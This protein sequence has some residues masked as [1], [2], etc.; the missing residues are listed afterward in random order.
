MFNASMYLAIS[1]QTHISLLSIQYRP[2]FLY[3]PRVFV[4]FA[5]ILQ[6]HDVLV[7][8]AVRHLAATITAIAN[9]VIT[10]TVAGIAWRSKRGG[11]VGQ[12]RGDVSRVDGVF[13]AMAMREAADTKIRRRRYSENVRI[14]NQA[15][16]DADRRYGSLQMWMHAMSMHELLRGGDGER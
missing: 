2:L 1:T 10:V 16:D 5:P 11:A 13:G 14:R 3:L 8:R 15:R 9:A 7:V 12:A 4:V 6:I